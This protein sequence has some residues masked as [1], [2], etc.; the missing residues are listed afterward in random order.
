MVVNR[1]RQ[2]ISRCSVNYQQSRWDEAS[3]MFSLFDA[4][5]WKTVSSLAHS[6]SARKDDKYTTMHKQV[7]RL[8][9]NNA[10][11]RSD[12][13]LLLPDSVW[14]CLQDQLRAGVLQHDC[15]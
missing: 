12:S 11:L 2:V 3:V 4:D 14:G 1:T 15:H 10:D 7:V 6:A 5:E 9:E 8:L 13:T